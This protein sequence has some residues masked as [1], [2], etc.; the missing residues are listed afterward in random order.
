MTDLRLPIYKNMSLQAVA[1]QLQ[2]DYYGVIPILCKHAREHAKYLQSKTIDQKLMYVVEHTLQWIGVIEDF[3]GHRNT[4]V[5]PYIN[6]LADKD[7]GGHNCQ[8]CSG[9]CEMQHT[10]KVMEI[11]TSLIHIKEQHRLFVDEL[12]ELLK[13][14]HPQDVKCL[15]NTSML[16]CNYLDELLRLEADILVP[17]IKDAQKNINAHI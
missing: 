4:L 9:R 14:V 7:S 6:E 16:L 13:G 8:L 2:D 17:R 15:N 3:I 12:P 10:A 11:T 1:G 5:K